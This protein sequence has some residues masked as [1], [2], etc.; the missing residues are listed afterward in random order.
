MKVDDREKIE[1]IKTW[2]NLNVTAHTWHDHRIKELWVIIGEADITMPPKIE[3]KRKSRD[4]LISETIARVTL[5]EIRMD[6][7][8]EES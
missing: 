3:L 2:I 6:K 7:L 8:E 5:L 4:Q 1:A